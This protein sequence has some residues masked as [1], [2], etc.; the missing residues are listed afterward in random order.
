MNKEI[1][2]LKNKL[3]ENELMIQALDSLIDKQRLVLERVRERLVE[4]KEKYER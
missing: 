2:E 3:A 4:E 1:E